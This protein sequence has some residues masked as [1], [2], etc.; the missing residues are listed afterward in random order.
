MARNPLNRGHFMMDWAK[1]G[2]IVTRAWQHGFN[3][4]TTVTIRILTRGN[5]IVT[6]RDGISG[7]N[8][9]L[10]PRRLTISYAT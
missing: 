8:I 7:S 2:S 1:I 3:D 9:S 5:G 10:A 6:R 4:R